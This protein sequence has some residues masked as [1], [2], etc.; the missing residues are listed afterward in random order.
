MTLTDLILAYP[1]TALVVFLAAV[2]A[3]WLCLSAALWAAAWVLGWFDWPRH[4]R[5][6]WQEL[7]ELWNS[8]RVCP[9]QPDNRGRGLTSAAGVDDNLSDLGT[10]SVNPARPPDFNGRSAAP[11]KMVTPH[12]RASHTEPSRPHSAPQVVS[13]S[14]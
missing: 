1:L 12:P 6:W 2:A 3:L 11:K 8:P 5:G 9:H 4:R 7:S 14:K 10:G 13:T